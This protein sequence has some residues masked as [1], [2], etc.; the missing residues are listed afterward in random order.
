M[1][2]WKILLFHIPRDLVVLIRGLFGKEA[3][4]V[5]SNLKRNLCVRTN[6]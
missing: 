5:S 1:C 2:M 4:N 6:F 3:V